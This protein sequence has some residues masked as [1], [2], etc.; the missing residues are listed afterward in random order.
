MAFTKGHNVNSPDESGRLPLEIALELWLSTDAFEGEIV[1]ILVQSQADVNATTSQENGDS[2][3]HI[4]ARYGNSNHC[5]ILLEN[6]ETC[7][8][9][10]LFPTLI[11][12]FF[13]YIVWS[14]FLIHVYATHKILCVYVNDCF[15]NCNNPIKQSLQCK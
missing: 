5:K 4:A 11:N 13:V 2:L 10:I 12:L 15:H 9:V 7:H 8:F 3:L 1:N 6:G 14:L